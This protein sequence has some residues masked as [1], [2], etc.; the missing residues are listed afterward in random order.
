[1]YTY[2]QNGPCKLKPFASSHKTAPVPLFFAIRRATHRGMHKAPIQVLVP[3]VCACLRDRQHK[4]RTVKVKWLSRGG[5]A[6]TCIKTG[7]RAATATV[8]ASA[9]AWI[10]IA[11]DASTLAATSVVDAAWLARPT[12]L[13]WSFFWIRQE[14]S[15]IEEPCCL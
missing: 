11:R 10:T 2:K 6:K 4:T 8:V 12:T 14:V 5:G 1:M 15:S 9:A 13:F 7:F 3:T